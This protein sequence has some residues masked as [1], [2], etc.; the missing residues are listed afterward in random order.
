MR[1]WSTA[2]VVFLLARQGAAGDSYDHIAREVAVAVHQAGLT[3]IYV[4]PFTSADGRSRSLGPMLRANVIERLAKDRSLKVLAGRPTD[5]AEGAPEGHLALLAGTY[6]NLGPT[7]R[8]ALELSD[9]ERGTISWT[10]ERALRNEWLTAE[11][12]DLS[13][14]NVAVEAS[15]LCADTTAQTDLDPRTLD[16]KARSWALSGG[17]NKG[18]EQREPWKAIHD[19]ALRKEFVERVQFWLGQADIPALT[20]Q[21]NRSLEEADVRSFARALEC[22]IRP[23]RKD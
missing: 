5:Q 19:P 11:P 16:V 10:A 22:P 9:R 20:D 21:E 3:D 7:I 8:L 4:P 1:A 13:P 17:T 12:E 14:Q 23:R 2:A 18:Q 6:I 15:P